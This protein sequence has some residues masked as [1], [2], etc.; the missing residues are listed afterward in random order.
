MER[1]NCKMNVIL[2]IIGLDDERIV[3]P[4]GSALHNR[5]NVYTFCQIW[6]PANLR[7]ST[8][9]VFVRKVLSILKSC[10]TNQTWLMWQFVTNSKIFSFGGLSRILSLNSKCAAQFPQLYIGEKSLARL[11]HQWLTTLCAKPS[12]KQKSKTL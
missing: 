7:K 5:D 11:S 9:F 6:N 3:S 8:D 10:Q 1:M 2:H 4:L 12:K